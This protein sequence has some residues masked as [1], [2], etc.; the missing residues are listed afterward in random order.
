MFSSVP[1]RDSRKYLSDPTDD[2][3]VAT[4]ILLADFLREI[5]EICSL[6]T[7]IDDAKPQRR[8]ED[9]ESPRADADVPQEPSE[10]AIF[11]N[12]KDSQPFYDN[13][14]KDDLTSEV[15]I[16]DTGGMC[17]PSSWKNAYDVLHSL[18]PWARCQD[19]FCCHHRD[20]D[21]ATGRR[22]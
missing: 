6:K 7:R 15:D 5:R 21:T 10:Q 20:I 22:T 11:L 18:A 16:R 4:E 8:N 1:N 17:P 2:V 9:G 3:K 14:A 13:E 12:E 19:R